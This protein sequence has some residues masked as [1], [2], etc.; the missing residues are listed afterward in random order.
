MS[1][2][3]AVCCCLHAPELLASH[4]ELSML[5]WPRS[6]TIYYVRCAVDFCQS[7]TNNLF[8]G[9]Y[10]S[11]TANPFL[12]SKTC[13]RYYM[14]LHFGEDM[15]ICVS[16]DYELGFP[17]SVPFAGFE[18][19]SA[20]NPLAANNP[21][22]ANPA[23]WPHGCPVGFT[24]HLVAVD[25][26]CEINFC[27][28]AG[29]FNQLQT[30]PPRLP[31]Y[32]KLKQNP[33]TTNTLVVIGLNGAI[34][35]KT[36][37]GDWIKEYGGIEDGKDWVTNELNLNPAVPVTDNGTLFVESSSSS[38]D[39]LSSGAVAGISITATLALCTI[40]AFAVFTGYSIKKKKEKSP[41]ETYLHINDDP[42]TNYD[43]QESN[44]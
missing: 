1:T 12:G 8:G 26:N 24:Q 18:S 30:M 35:F 10:T 42:P 14:P 6:A 27:I 39:S 4:S 40:I 25:E 36:A 23:S 38:S 13:P 33:N 3:C 16:D 32:R 41:D 2:I 22:M 15:F 44:A 37:D 43:P 9:F 17:F 28:K 34:W 7:S 19:C 5:N 20:G 29:S 21:S 11:S 31:P